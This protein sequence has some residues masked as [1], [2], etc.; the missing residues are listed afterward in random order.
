MK[1]K[2]GISEVC[3]LIDV[4]VFEYLVY[5]LEENFDVVIFFVR[6]VIKVV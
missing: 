2:L 4:I 1:G 6:K 5:F 3:F